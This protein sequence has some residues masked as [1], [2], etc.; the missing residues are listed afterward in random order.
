MESDSRKARASRLNREGPG[1]TLGVQRA[2]VGSA[3]H[4]PMI[5][6]PGAHEQPLGNHPLPVLPQR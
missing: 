2:T 4:K 3:E 6:E 1:E 5:D